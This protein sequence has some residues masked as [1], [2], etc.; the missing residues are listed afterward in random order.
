MDKRDNIDQFG[1]DPDNVTV[2][3]ESGG[4]AKVFALI[5]SPYAK[6]CSIKVLSK[7]ERQR[8]WEQSLPT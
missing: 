6:D 5:A 7:A 1:G 8:I 2:F 4:G 3:G